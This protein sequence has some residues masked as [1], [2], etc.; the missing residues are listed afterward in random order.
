MDASI[1]VDVAHSWQRLRNL[2]EATQ[3]DPRTAAG[4]IAR[5]LA[6]HGNQAHIDQLRDMVDA[7]LAV[8]RAARVA[9]AELQL[10]SIWLA[11][12]EGARA[13]LGSR[14]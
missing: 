6:A 8:R 11:V 1:P 14:Q 3:T 12:L 4:D 9:V 10:H 13:A 5:S 7:E 2:A